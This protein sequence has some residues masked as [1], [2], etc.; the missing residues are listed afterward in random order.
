MKK[1]RLNCIAALV[2]VLS[3][4]TASQ[5][6]IAKGTSLV[7]G[8]ISFSS[9]K[10]ENSN[11]TDVTKNQGFGLSP[12]YG[13]AIRQNL[14][15]GGDLYFSNTTNKI[16]HTLYGGSNMQNNAYGLGVFARQYRNLGKSGFYLFLQSRLGADLTSGKYTYTHPNNTQPRK[17]SG[18]N[19]G[20]SVY[21]GISYA[22][23]QRFHIET[24]LNDLVYARY[25][26]I[27]TTNTG[28]NAQV[29]NKS[30]NFNIGASLGSTI[31]WSI[32]FRFLWGS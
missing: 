16:T 6:Q 19:I 17:S 8:S 20:V 27:K 10:Q 2:T 4:S 14:V 3:I 12:S 29:T 21:P 1:V 22:V 5:A 30:S 23:T 7:G 31:Q 15:V 9:E 11:G 28:T 32:G 25:S 13:M 24:G 18:Y 26:G